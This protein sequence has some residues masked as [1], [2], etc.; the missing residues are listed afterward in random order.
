M[1]WRTMPTLCLTLL[2]LASTPPALVAQAAQPAH[3]LS[4]TPASPTS[5]DVI[6][7]KLAGIWPDNLS[8]E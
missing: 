4:V 1:R 3:T 7:L 5:Q 6:T 2:L 8:A